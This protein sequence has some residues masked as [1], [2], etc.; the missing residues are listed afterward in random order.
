MS[1]SLIDLELVFII[2]S[3]N[4]NVNGHTLY[5]KLCSY[6]LRAALMGFA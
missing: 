3:F 4:A 1:S 2:A 6:G 5:I